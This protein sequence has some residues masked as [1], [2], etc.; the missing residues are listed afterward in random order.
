MGLGDLGLVCTLGGGSTGT[1]WSISP[2]TERWG[3]SS[4]DFWI[5]VKTLLSGL[6]L[7]NPPKELCGVNSTVWFVPEIGLKSFAMSSPLPSSLPSS[8][9]WLSSS[10]SSSV[11]KLELSPSSSG[12][13]GTSLGGIRSLG[14][15][16]SKL[17]LASWDGWVG[18]GV[19]LGIKSGGRG[20]SV[21]ADET[22]DSPAAKL[23]LLVVSG[24]KGASGTL[25][26]RAPIFPSDA[27]SSFI[28]GETV[29][30]LAADGWVAGEAK[31]SGPGVTVLFRPPKLKLSDLRCSAGL[32][33]LKPAENAGLT[34]ES[35]DVGLA[36]PNSLLVGAVDFK[37]WFFGAAGVDA[38]VV[39]SGFRGSSGLVSSSVVSM[40]ASLDR[41]I[42]I[43][44]C[45]AASPR[46]LPK[47]PPKKE[48]LAPLEGSRSSFSAELSAL[49]VDPRTKLFEPNRLFVLLPVLLLVLPKGELVFPPGL[50]LGVAKLPEADLGPNIL[51]V[52]LGA[53]AAAANPPL[54]AK[55]ANP[56]EDGAV[57][58]VLG[59]G[60]PN[61]EVG[62][63]SPPAWPKTEGV[64][65]EPAVPHGDGRLPGKPELLNNRLLLVAPKVGAP[66]AGVVPV[67]GP[68]AA[69]G[70]GV[71]VDVEGAPHRGR[72]L[73]KLDGAPKVPVVLLPR[74]DG[75]PNAVA[76]LALPKALTVLG[77]PKVDDPNVGF[78]NPPK[79]EVEVCV[80]AG[81]DCWACDAPPAE[82]SPG[83]IVFCRMES[84]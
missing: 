74:S 35:E 71:V 7:F 34:A 51:P 10:S 61:T 20:A 28:L 55:D 12:P 2:Y 72:L 64:A 73:P 65:M 47:V 36:V 30:G 39:E 33:K 32:P 15:R 8:R 11:E 52:A 80:G 83:Y 56:P 60:V 14:M 38:G 3:L 44:V 31:V 57:A 5:L 16:V 21:P 25:S 75:A 62:L 77:A 9:W 6:R 13:P 17:G 84:E 49:K 68:N 67:A 1:E 66:K 48:L 24:G 58:P 79:R 59:V 18:L 22:D 19:V 23:V 70:L 63:P 40:S 82:T 78:D 45:F 46:A 4:P 37:N 26:P 76:G 27:G 54:E 43:A 53:G 42:S 50:G 41:G 81:D 29:L 69:L